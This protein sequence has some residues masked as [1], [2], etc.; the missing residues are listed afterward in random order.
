MFLLFF[1]D[2]TNLQAVPFEAISVILSAML[3]LN[4]STIFSAVFCVALLE[5]VSCASVADY[6]VTI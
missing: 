5:P 4:K 3:F 1:A 2:V 6:F